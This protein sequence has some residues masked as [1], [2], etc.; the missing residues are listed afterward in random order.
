MLKW[1]C[2][3]FTSEEI[4]VY[5]NWGGETD[6]PWAYFLLTRWP[7]ARSSGES[8]FKIDLPPKI[9]EYKLSIDTVLCN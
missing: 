3:N 6:R 7:K 4:Q 8:S 2:F 5:K 9:L 1:K